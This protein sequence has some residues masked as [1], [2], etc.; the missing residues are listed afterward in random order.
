MDALSIDA[1]I[2]LYGEN[3]NKMR[4]FALAVQRIARI[5]RMA[6]VG[7]KHTKYEYNLFLIG[8]MSAFGVAHPKLSTQWVKSVFGMVKISIYERANTHKNAHIHIKP[9]RKANVRLSN[10]KFT[11]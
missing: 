8:C 6:S 7:T 2:M 5:E 11:K 1:F 9:I 4:K 3:V 10:W